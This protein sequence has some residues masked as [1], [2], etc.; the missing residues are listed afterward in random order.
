MR[1]RELVSFYRRSDS[2]GA[3]DSFAL[4]PLTTCD[5]VCITMSTSFVTSGKSREPAV[6][7]RPLDRR[8]LLLFSLCC[9][10]SGRVMSLLSSTKDDLRNDSPVSARGRQ[11]SGASAWEP[12]GLLPD[13]QQPLDVG[14][15][16]GHR[17]HLVVHGLGQLA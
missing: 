5:G 4:G 14:A 7:G 11:R 10:G 17:G 15:A 1:H 12:A 8:R 2:S 6:D 13:G 9:R 3:R 16:A